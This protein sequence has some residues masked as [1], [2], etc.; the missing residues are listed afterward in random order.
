MWVQVV[1]CAWNGGHGM[2]GNLAGL[3]WEFFEKHP[4]VGA[5]AR[6]NP[7]GGGAAVLV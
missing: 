4:K 2:W 7:S 6:K 3:I 5:A 1:R